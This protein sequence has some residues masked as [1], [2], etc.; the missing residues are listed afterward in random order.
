MPSAGYNK[1]RAEG[2]IM[3]CLIAQ[4]VKPWACLR[5]ELAKVLYLKGPSDMTGNCRVC[6]SSN[7]IT[8]PLGLS[9][10]R[11]AIGYVAKLGFDCSPSV[12]IGDPLSS[13][14]VIVS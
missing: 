4:F 12:M 14:A 13:K 2:E 8:T 9:P 1:L 11:P 7:G 10:L 6:P 5:K 3:A